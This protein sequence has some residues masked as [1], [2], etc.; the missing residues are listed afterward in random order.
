MADP[1]RM[2]R[3]DRLGQH[4][5]ERRAE[6]MGP[7]GAEPVEQGDR[8]VGNAQEIADH[9]IGNRNDPNVGRQGRDDLAENIGVAQ[10]AGAQEQALAARR[11]SGVDDPPDAAPDRDRLSRA[12]GAEG[13]GFGAIVGFDAHWAS[14]ARRLSVQGRFTAGPSGLQCGRRSPV[15]DS[16]GSGPASEIGS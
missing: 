15:Q 2:A 4:A 16:C 5:A 9:R 1:V 6:N 7:A 13:D 12:M 3:A 11:R 10:R 8:A 14:S